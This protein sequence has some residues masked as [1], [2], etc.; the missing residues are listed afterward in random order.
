MTDTPAPTS[1]DYIAFADAVAKAWPINDPANVQPLHKLA[2]RF[3]CDREPYTLWP[4]A[5]VLVGKVA[6]AMLAAHKARSERTM[7]QVDF[8]ECEASNDE[9]SEQQREPVAWT[10]ELA[11]CCSGGEYGCWQSHLSRDKPNV[12]NGSIRD[13]IPLYELP[14]PGVMTSTEATCDQIVAAV[15]T[16][17][18]AKINQDKSYTYNG[19]VKNAKANLLGVLR[20]LLPV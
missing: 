13:L 15:C 4:H 1:Q 6:R 9:P 12:P 11:H 2:Q 20:K 17:M 16:L 5:S 14:E 7:A 8:G 19:I 3:N 18:D 10:Y